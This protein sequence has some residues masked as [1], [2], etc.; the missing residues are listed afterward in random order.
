MR[1]LLVAM[2]VSQDER[3]TRKSTA[4]GLDPALRAN[5]IK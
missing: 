2:F 4:V 1:S 5:Q 3:A